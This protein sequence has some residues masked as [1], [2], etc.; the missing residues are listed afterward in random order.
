MQGL[1]ATPSLRRSCIGWRESRKSTEAVLPWPGNHE[2]HRDHRPS[3][4]SGDGAEGER[5][6]EVKFRR[7]LR[8]ALFPKGTPIYLV[9]AI[10]FLLSTLLSI[11]LRSRL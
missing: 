5:K 4:A 1:K 10:A 11:Y 9:A 6:S 2:P 7:W 8:D 3:L